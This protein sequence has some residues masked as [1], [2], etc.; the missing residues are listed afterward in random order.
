M[1]RSSFFFFLLAI[2]FRIGHHSTS[3]DSTA[4]RSSDEI[5][6]WTRYDPIIRYRSYLESVGLWC[7]QRDI[8]LKKHIK[9]S[10][11]LAFTEAEKEHKACWKEL[12]T[13]VYCTM[14]KHIRFV[15]LFF[16]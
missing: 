8:E 10:V 7:E 9:N 3:D 16:Y 14:P 13:D 2:Y 5:A 12:F 4:Y 6:Y 15:C 1:L 11:L